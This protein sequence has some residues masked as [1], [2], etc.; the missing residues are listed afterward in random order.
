MDGAEQYRAWIG[1][2]RTARDI[3]AAAPVARLSATLDRDDPAP[4]PGD[5]LPPAWHWLYFLETVPIKGL[6]PDGHAARGDF[7]PPVP[8]PRRMSAGGRFRFIAPIRIG[9]AIERNSEIVDIALK[10]GRSGPLAFCTVRHTIGNAAGAC[11]V[12]EHDIVYRE[13]PAPGETPAP[14][15][16]PPAGGVFGRTITPDPVLLF[17]FSALTFNGHRIHY[18][19]PYVTKVEGYPGLVVH[20]PLL[21]ILLLDLVRRERPGAALRAFAF[22]AFRPVFDTS[23]FQVAGKPDRT[24]LLLWA[25]DNGGALAMRA[26]AKLA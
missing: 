6:G 16:P 11:V 17:R 9:D 3:A 10:E 19:H 5:P 13:A 4:Q 26:E 24:G 2:K 8:L 12:E 7:L 14:A 23:P 15:Q 21:A 18:D 1:R 20:G 22:R 25:E